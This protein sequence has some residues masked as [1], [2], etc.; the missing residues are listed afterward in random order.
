VSGG[1]QAGASKRARTSSPAFGGRRWRRR[2][3]GS[4]W[5]RYLV[6][7]TARFVYA[8][9]DVL[10]RTHVFLAA[11]ADDELT[12]QDTEEIQAAR[13]GTLAELSGP[14]RERLLATGRAFWRYRVSLHDAAV[15]AIARTTE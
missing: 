8:P 4:S 15:E 12:P 2:G 5:Q 1:R 7:A 3:C 13:W 10:W 9:S 14:L 11:T 6:D